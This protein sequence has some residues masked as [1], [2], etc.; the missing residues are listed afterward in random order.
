MSRAYDKIAVKLPGLRVEVVG[1]R[2]DKAMRIFNKKVQDSGL[3]QTLQERE[4]YEKPSER[5]RRK[6]ALARKRWL[7]EQEKNALPKRP[8]N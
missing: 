2:F 3:L 5:A 4:R 7:K 8:R 1:D 6:K